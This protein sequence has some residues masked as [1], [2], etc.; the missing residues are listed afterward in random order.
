MTFFLNIFQQELSK[1][2]NLFHFYLENQSNTAFDIELFRSMISD[3]TVVNI[4]ELKQLF[5]ALQFATGSSGDLIADLSDISPKVV[6]GLMKM[7]DQELTG[8]MA[9][10]TNVGKC[11]ID[12]FGIFLCQCG[13]FHVGEDCSKDRRACSS[14]PCQNNATCIE[15]ENKNAS[16]TYSCKCSSNLFY[17]SIILLLTSVLF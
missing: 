8:C 16:N 2:N 10:C 3:P 12:D 1:I 13:E 17:G 15:I 4:D 9:N 11:I 7:E 5:K 6:V 14:T